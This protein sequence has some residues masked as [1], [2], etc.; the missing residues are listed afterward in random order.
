MNHATELINRLIDDWE[1][2]YTDHP[3]DRGGP[4][5]FGITQRVY[6]DFL[7]RPAAAEEVRLMPRSHAVAIYRSRYWDKPKIAL[8]PEPL[9]PVVFDMGVNHG[10]KTAVKL[11]QRALGDLGRRVGVDGIIGK[12]TSGVAA[13]AVA[14]LGAA[15]V[16]NTVCDR[17][18]GRTDK[19]IAED[20]T[21]ACFAKGWQ[22]RCDSFRVPA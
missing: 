6:G 4:T 16:V 17:R 20:P 13:R 5:N 14:D 22:R 18:Q 3:N 7:G 10:P 19:I 9:Q 1:G 12:I 2:G 15:A 11:L 21:Q 8:L